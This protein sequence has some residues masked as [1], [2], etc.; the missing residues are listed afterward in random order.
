MKKLTVLFLSI[1]FCATYTLQAQKTFSGE[2]VFETRLEGTDD[3][4]L[5]SSLE[6]F[7]TTVSILGNKSKTVMRPN[8]MAMI[9]QIWNGDNGTSS[10]VIE[11]MGMGKFYKKWSAEEHKEKLKFSEFSF[12]PQ[13]EFKDILGYKCQKVIATI[14]NLEDDSQKEVI[15]FVTKEIG[16]AK[17]NG[18][19]YPGLEGFPL[20]ILSPLDEYCE[21]C[22]LTQVAIKITPKK[23]K[24]VDFLLPDDAKNI[25]DEPELKQMLGF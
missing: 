8:D 14:T 23:I 21:E 1:L 22:T 10:M 6:N 5:L 20:V 18:A 2:I 12:S 7:T 13:N 15:L 3:P 19:E 24:D 11:L 25:D 4:N 17:L 16:S 9:T